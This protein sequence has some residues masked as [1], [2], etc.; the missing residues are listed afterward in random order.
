[1]AL[2]TA[3]R[4]R[5]P[6][7][8]RR[9]RGSLNSTTGEISGTPTTAETAN[10]TVEV[11]DSQGTPDTDQQALSITI[12]SVPDPLVITGCIRLSAG[13]SLAQ[14]HDRRDIGYS[15]DG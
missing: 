14:L 13:G 7:G 8:S 15:D 2:P 4:L 12:T 5:R 6:A 11:T 10:F 9:T 1:M 3:R